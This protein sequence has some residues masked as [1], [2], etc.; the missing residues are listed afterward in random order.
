MARA[1]KRGATGGHASALGGGVGKGVG[2]VLGGEREPG[3]RGPQQHLADADPVVGA[4]RGRKQRL[5]VVAAHKGRGAPAELGARHL[6]EAE[7][8]VAVQEA[9][10]LEQ[11]APG[12]LDTLWWSQV[13]EQRRGRKDQQRLQQGCMQ[14][15]DSLL[16]HHGSCIHI[17]HDERA[18]LPCCRCPSA[19]GQCCRTA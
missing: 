10:G 11:E 16:E 4:A 17:E 19:R 1:C 15:P 3:R 6:Q 2:L 13:Q 8:D 18:R 14:L 12:G 5:E 9:Q 7:R